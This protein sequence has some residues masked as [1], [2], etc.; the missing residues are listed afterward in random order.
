MSRGLWAGAVALALAL[1]ATLSGCGS[2]LPAP[3]LGPHT[4]EQAITVPFP[5]PPGK[6]EI[7]P[8]RPRIPKNAV[9]I[10]GEWQW[11]SQHWVWSPGRWQLP[12]AGGYWAPP[13]T[14]RQSD[15]TLTHFAGV[16]KMGKPQ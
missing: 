15:G 3:V 1:G 4:G 14:E 6:V 7:V 8:P 12:P 13:K 9:W 16:W 11:K 5:P 2:E 10:D